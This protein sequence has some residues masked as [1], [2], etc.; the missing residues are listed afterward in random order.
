[1]ISAEQLSVTGVMRTQ[2][3]RLTAILAASLVAAVGAGMAVLLAS[4]FPA[5]GLLTEMRDSKSADEYRT[6]T[7]VLNQPDS[8]GCRRRI[9]DAPRS[10]FS[11]V[12]R[13]SRP[14][15]CTVR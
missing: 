8:N 7:I 13:S 4:K 15:C 5:H 11:A 1:M 6:G 12:S 9:F 2:Q 3:A 10:S 14:P